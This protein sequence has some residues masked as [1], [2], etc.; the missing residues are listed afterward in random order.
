MRFET[1]LQSNTCWWSFFSVLLK[2]RLTF[3]SDPSVRP[4]S[5]IL[6]T[7]LRTTLGGQRERKIPR[8]IEFHMGQLRS[9][10]VSSGLKRL[11]FFFLIYCPLT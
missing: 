5:L 2:D 10:Y 7:S 8:E 4:C 6:E 3:I 1:S 9:C 11:L